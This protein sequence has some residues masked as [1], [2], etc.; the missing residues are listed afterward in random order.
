MFSNSTIILKNKMQLVSKMPL[1]W[2]LENKLP[3]VFRNPLKNYLNSIAEL[4][5]Q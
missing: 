1:A 2:L 3:E 5:I 4:V